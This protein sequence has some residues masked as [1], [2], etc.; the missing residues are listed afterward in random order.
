MTALIPEVDDAT[1]AE[2]DRIGVEATAHAETTNGA[3][4]LAQT[5][6]A[7][8]VADS[9]AEGPDGQ[10]IKVLR[11]APTDIELAALVAVLTAA[12]AGPSN[13]NGQAAPRAEETWGHPTLMH[14]YPTAFAPATFT[15]SPQLRQ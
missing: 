5:S 14:R 7:A 10:V 8:E 13:G 4:E 9:T 15:V 2:L 3:A 1:A 6:A 12:A 11:G